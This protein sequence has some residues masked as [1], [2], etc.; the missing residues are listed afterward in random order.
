MTRRD[1]G[2]F[3]ADLD[4]PTPFTRPCPY[5]HA[6]PRQPCTRP[7]RRRGGRVE[8]R[9]YHDSRVYPPTNPERTLP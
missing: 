9:G 1:D 3:P 2:R 6:A 7:S 4:G 8:L 5:C